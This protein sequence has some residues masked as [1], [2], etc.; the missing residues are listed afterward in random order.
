MRQTMPQVLEPL[1]PTA[2][3][4]RWLGLSLPSVDKIM[5]LLH[6][7]TSMILVPW[8]LM[9]AFSGFAMSHPHWFDKWWS[10][11]SMQTVREIPFT[12]AADFPK[13]RAQQAQALLKLTGLEGFH[14]IAGG[15]PT[16]GQEMTVIRIAALGR[17]NVIW[18]P[19]TRMIVVQQENF[20]FCSWMRNLHFKAGYHSTTNAYWRNWLWSI[21][22]DATIISLVF[23]V[24]SGFWMWARRR[25]HRWQV[26]LGMVLGLAFFAWLAL[27]L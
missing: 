16:T 27:S 12:P 17:W 2:T 20:G 24:L 14:Q 26:G 23:W 8:V 5:R 9:Y 19:Q 1:T 11:G 3:R 21:M 15:N 22:V 10:S 13:E 6:L 7:Y 18:R 4:T 25:A